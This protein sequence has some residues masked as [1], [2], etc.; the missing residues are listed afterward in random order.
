MA[1]KTKTEIIAEVAGCLGGLCFVRNGKVFRLY[2]SA[3]REYG[4]V[5]VDLRVTFVCESPQEFVIV[6]VHIFMD[7][8]DK[9]EFLTQL[10]LHGNL[11]LAT[12]QDVVKWKLN[13]RKN[14]Q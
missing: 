9:K 10:E 14:G 11:K 12:P 4:L 1:S 6:P 2:D 13:Q 8:V 7:V 3:I 5:K